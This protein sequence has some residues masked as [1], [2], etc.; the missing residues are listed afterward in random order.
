M[1]PMISQP[2]SYLK[3][4]FAGLGA[5]L[6]SLAA[7]AAENGLSLSEGLLAAAGAVVTFSATYWVTNQPVDPPGV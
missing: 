3:A 7:G 5:G 1:I 2:A 4:I 6:T